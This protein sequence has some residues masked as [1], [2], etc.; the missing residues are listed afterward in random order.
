MIKK[1]EAVGCNR[2]QENFSFSKLALLT[3][4]TRFSGE[5]GKEEQVWKKREVA[6]KG[7]QLANGEN[8][9]LHSIIF[10]PR[11]TSLS[12]RKIFPDVVNHSFLAA[13]LDRYEADKCLGEEKS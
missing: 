4:R 1:G 9:G 13:D 11:V 12:R 8:Q 10:P 3:Q 7:R 5:D 2:Q 6:G